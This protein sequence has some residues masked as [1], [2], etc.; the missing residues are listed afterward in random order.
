MVM[1]PTLASRVDAVNSRATVAL[2]KER[3]NVDADVWE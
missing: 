2:S 1:G 3:L